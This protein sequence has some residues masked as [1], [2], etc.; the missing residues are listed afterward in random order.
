MAHDACLL[1][2]GRV[3]VAGGWSA[4]RKATTPTAEIYNPQANRWIPA[5]DLPFHAHDLFLIPLPEGH[6]LA[7]AGK[8]TT[9]DDRTAHAVDS[10]ALLRVK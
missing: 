3:L 4:A 2:D 5:S 10:A 1:D 8:S 9:G 6:V 7:V